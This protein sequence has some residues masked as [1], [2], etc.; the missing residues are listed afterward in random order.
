MSDRDLLIAELIHE[1]AVEIRKQFG[2]EL[3]TVE[4]SDELRE[5]SA[6]ELLHELAVEFRKAMKKAEA[7]ESPK[8]NIQLLNDHEKGAV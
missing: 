3:K 1:L 5:M 6:P 2:D 8:R 7:T 4:V